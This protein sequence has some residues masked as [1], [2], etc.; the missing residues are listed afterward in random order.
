MMRRSTRTIG[1]GGWNDNT[2]RTNDTFLEQYIAVEPVLARRH[3]PKGAAGAF[4]EC[5]A[6]ER[7]EAYVWPGTSGDNRPEFSEDRNLLIGLVDD[8][9]APGRLRNEIIQG[10]DGQHGI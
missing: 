5:K 9:H 4:V 8:L 6:L 7:C 2:A 1:A 10:Q 3:H